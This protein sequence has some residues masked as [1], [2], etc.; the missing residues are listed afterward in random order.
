MQPFRCRFS[1]KLVR[2][3]IDQWGWQLLAL[4]FSLQLKLAARSYQARRSVTIHNA[5][6]ESKPKMWDS[7][8]LH[9][10][11]GSH[12]FRPIHGADQ[13]PLQLVESYVAKSGVLMCFVWF[14]LLS[15]VSQRQ[16]TKCQVSWRPGCTWV[17]SLCSCRQPQSHLHLEI[18]SW[19][20]YFPVQTC[21]DFVLW[22]AMVCIITPFITNSELKARMLNAVVC[23]L[24]FGW[25]PLRRELVACTDTETKIEHASQILSW[26]WSWSTGCSR[27]GRDTWC[28]GFRDWSSANVGASCSSFAVLKG[29]AW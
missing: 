12:A 24:P 29:I 22:K 20:R 17:A 11:T 10:C 18:A 1:V 4:L 25:L 15:F 16:L 28:S 7:K 23:S 21:K 8:D 6:S 3:P 26:A 27:D 19:F 13:F 14:L 5:S 2:W 9:M